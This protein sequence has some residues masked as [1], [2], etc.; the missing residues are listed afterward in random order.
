MA[1][2]ANANADDTRRRVVDAAIP[3]FAAHGFHGASTR[4]LAAAARVNVAT[5]SHYYES[6]QGLFDAAVDEV[7]RRLG[8]RGA[9]VLVGSSPADLDTL[10]ARLYVVARAERDGVRLLVR[11]VLDHGRLTPRTESKHFVP[12]LRQLA[13]QTSLLL[14]VSVERARSAAVAVSYLLSRYVIQDDDSLTVAFGVRSVKEAHARAI[15]TLT[16][17]AHALLGARAK[18]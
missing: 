18:E 6:K 16:A 3:L 15:A 11:Q 1:R 17:T 8:A 14:G 9:E 4:E 13:R 12:E 2:P 7:Y 5:L 10:L